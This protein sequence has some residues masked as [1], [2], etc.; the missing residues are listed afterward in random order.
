MSQALVG[1][2]VCKVAV[3]QKFPA[4][5]GWRHTEMFDESIGQNDAIMS[6]AWAVS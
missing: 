5:L 1:K 4:A 3:L 6:G 2:S